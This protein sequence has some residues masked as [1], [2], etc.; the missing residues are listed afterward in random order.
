MAT[1][2]KQHNL[3]FFHIPKNGGTS[4]STWLKEHLNGQKGIRK[5]SG[6][7]HIK[8][9]WPDIVD[10]ITFAVIRNPWERLVSLYHFDGKKL[11]ARLDKGK[12]KGEDW[13]ESTL[14]Q[15]KLY[16][17]GFEPWL[18]EGLDYGNYWFTYKYNQSEWIPSDPTYLLRFENLIEDFKIIQNYTKCYYSLTKENSTSHNHYT[19]YYTT[20]SKNFVADI[21]KEDI[22]RFNYDF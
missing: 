2:V 21:F 9:E 7:Q 15:Y 19:S 5:H 18:Y 13:F 22:D 3:I 1:F 12:G 17:K 20:D 6:M 14:K 10:P 8:E 16:E 11:K 4:I